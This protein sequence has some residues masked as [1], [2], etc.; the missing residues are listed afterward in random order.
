M[1]E[2]KYRG[3]IRQEEVVKQLQSGGAK[4]NKYVGN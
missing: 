2:S 4:V 3:W 1:A